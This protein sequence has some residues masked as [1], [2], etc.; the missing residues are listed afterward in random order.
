VTNE[1]LI[2]KAISA[3][4]ALATSGKLNPAQ[5]DKFIDYVV[6]E[7]VMKGS[8]RTVRFRNE[9]LHIDKIGIGKRVMYPAT[10]YEAPQH[11]SGVQTSQIK[12]Q[13]EEVIAAFDITDTFKEIN[14]E[15]E[16]VEDHII[17]MFAKGWSNDEETL[18]IGGDT[19]GPAILEGD[20]LDGGS[21]TQYVLDKLLALY[22]GWWRKADG[23]H[24]VNVAGANIGLTVFGQMIRA[25]PQ[26]FRRNKKDL[27]FFMSSDLAQIYIEKIATRMTQ[28]GDRAAEGETQTPF[29]IPIVEVPLI[30][31]QQQVV[32]SVTLDDVTP[33][34][35]RYAPVSDVVVLPNDL[36]KTPTTPYPNGLTGGYILDATAGTL[37]SFDSG[38]GLDGV[39]VKVTYKSN[40]QIVLTHWMNFILGIGRD[41]R[42]ERARNIHKRANEYVVTGK[43]SVQME[44]VDAVVKAYNVGT[45]V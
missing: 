9:E 26:K 28:K 17:K 42:I 30:D 10:E 11:R 45:G 22:D 13:P 24:L 15:G 41:I 29:G 44:E 12:L 8:V 43:I 33:V 6:D 34:N 38:S 16:S 21:T 14:L 2:Q 19:V 5:A 25:M 36:D 7:S 23:G 32:E 37:L 27:R 39:T 18:S 3:A 31:L 1:E 35:L 40:P 4:E 20:Y